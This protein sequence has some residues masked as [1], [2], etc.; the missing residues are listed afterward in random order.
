MTTLREAAKMAL[1]WLEK[2]AGSTNDSLEKW[3]RCADAEK[4]LRAALAAEQGESRW[5]PIETA[6]EDGTFF[7]TTDGALFEVLNKP[8]NHYLGFWTKIK[9][10]W[11]GNCSTNTDPT[12][13]IP[14]PQALVPN[15][16]IVCGKPLGSV[17]DIHTCSPQVNK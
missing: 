6:P 16:C 2:E 1:E 4:A 12:H 17:E 14:L 5:K 15:Y 13:W 10:Q 9:G 11:R 7:L 3:Q 8:K